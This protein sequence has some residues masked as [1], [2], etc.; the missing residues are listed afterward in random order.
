MLLFWGGVF[1]QCVF[2]KHVRVCV[3]SHIWVNLVSVNSGTLRVSCLYYG[4]L[5]SCYLNLSS[6]STRSRRVK[7]KFHPKNVE[8]VPKKVQ[9]SW[10]KLHQSGVKEGLETTENVG[11][12]GPTAKQEIL[13]S[14]FLSTWTVVWFLILVQ[15]SSDKITAS[16]PPYWHGD[17]CSSCYGKRFGQ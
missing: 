3:H 6:V 8:I 13:T 12:K 1:S 7:A 17:K 16:F 14:Y 2:C 9:D 10:V 15:W 4:Q 11:H 5:I